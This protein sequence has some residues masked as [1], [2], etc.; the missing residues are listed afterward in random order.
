MY[1]NGRTPQEEGGVPPPLLFQCLRL[2]AKNLLRCL[3]CQE[4]LRFK[5]FWSAFGGDHRGTVGG[6]GVPAKPP[7]PAPSNTTLGQGGLISALPHPVPHE[8]QASFIRIK[9]Q[10]RGGGLKLWTS[11]SYNSEGFLGWAPATPSFGHRSLV[12]L[13]AGAPFRFVVVQAPCQRGQNNV[14]PAHVFVLHMLG[15]FRG[16][17]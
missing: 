16:I 13:V 2:T 15:T 1:W 3:R 17:Q 12:W 14:G 7:S 4:D 9:L 8:G 10:W 6:G 11:P 5:N